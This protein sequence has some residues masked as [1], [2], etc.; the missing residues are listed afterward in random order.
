MSD[1]MSADR[2]KA[3]A[4]RI[5]APDADVIRI[6]K[7]MES[8]LIDEPMTRNE[9]RQAAKATKKPKALRGKP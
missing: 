9:R 4:Y 5:M 7:R 3:E 2:E 8:A 1:E 6:I